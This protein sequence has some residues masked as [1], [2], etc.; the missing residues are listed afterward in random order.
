MGAASVV[1]GGAPGIRRVRA[2]V[3]ELGGD[4]GGSRADLRG[5]CSPHECGGRRAVAGAGRKVRGVHETDQAPD[6]VALLT[7]A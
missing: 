1:Y 4:P 2:N 7:S 6:S 3:A 5:V